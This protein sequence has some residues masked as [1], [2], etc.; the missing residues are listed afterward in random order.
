MSDHQAKV[1]SIETLDKFQKSTL[2]F[3]EE[4][5]C[6]FDSIRCEIQRYQNIINN[7]IPARINRTLFKWEEIL[8]EAKI[9]LSSARTQSGKVAA[10]QKIRLAKS[11]I[12]LA[13][14]DK[15]K[16]RKWQMKLPA[17]LPTPVSILTK[18]KTFLVNDITKAATALQK[19]VHI[20]EEYS[21]Q[22]GQ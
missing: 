1:T 3:T 4:A 10:E 19:Y 21:G 6:I 17:L 14:E 22:N 16:I 13:E 8:K 15:Q 9:E 12:K 2:L 7:E 20:L 5:L 11:K 18:G